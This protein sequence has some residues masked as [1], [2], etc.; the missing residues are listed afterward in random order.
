M[1]TPSV[2][3]QFDITALG[4]TGDDV[5]HLFDNTKVEGSATLT[6]NG[7]ALE[8]GADSGGASLTLVG[9]LYDWTVVY[10]WLHPAT[11]QIGHEMNITHASGYATHPRSFN[12]NMNAAEYDITSGDGVGIVARSYLPGLWTHTGSYTCLI[13]G[14]TALT[15]PT[16]P[17]AASTAATFKM[18]EEGATDN[19]M[20]ASLIVQQLGASLSRPNPNEVVYGFTVNGNITM[21]GATNF[22]PAGALGIPD[23]DNNSDGTADVTLTGQFASS[24]TF[25]G[26]CFGRSHIINVTTGEV[27]RGQTTLRGIGALTFG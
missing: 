24:R 25:S 16:A 15:L 13:D 7:A 4:A 22:L 3:Y 9:G 14:T 26:T 11:P 1:G 19:E 8:A 17:G 27:I 6:I 20:T 21:V 18:T 12:I 23:W 10:D 5:K 2:G